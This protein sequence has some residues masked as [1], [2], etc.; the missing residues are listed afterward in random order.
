MNNDTIKLTTTQNSEALE[1]WIS[2]LKQSS[3]GFPPFSRLYYQQILSNP[4]QVIDTLLATLSSHKSRSLIPDGYTLSLH[5]K[6]AIFRD[7]RSHAKQ[8][9]RN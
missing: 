1:L 9:R 8:K 7:K 6:Q 5:Q 3:T 4:S 2:L